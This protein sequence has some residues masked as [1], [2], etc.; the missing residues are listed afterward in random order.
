VLG[1]EEAVRR[2]V[3]AALLDNLIFEPSIFLGLDFR[4]IMIC[5]LSKPHYV[6]DIGPSSR[7]YNLI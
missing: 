4:I 1:L 6:H 2:A 7:S 5:A 3:E